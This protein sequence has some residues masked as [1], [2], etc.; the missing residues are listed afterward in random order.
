MTNEGAGPK[1]RLLTME[2]EN[3]AETNCKGTSDYI[4]MQFDSLATSP[5]C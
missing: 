5:Y 4:S 2:A 3:Q 1:I